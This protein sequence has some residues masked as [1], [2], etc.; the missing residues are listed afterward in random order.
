MPSIKELIMKTSLQETKSLKFE[1]G[2]QPKS[3]SAVHIAADDTLV[4]DCNLDGHNSTLMYGMRS[5]HWMIRTHDFGGILNHL[6]H[7]GVEVYFPT[8]GDVRVVQA[9]GTVYCL[10][11]RLKKTYEVISLVG[12]PILPRQELLPKLF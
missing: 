3:I 12:R 10:P 4:L 5:R 11:Y 8:D 1:A 6:S 2:I 9:D 7:L